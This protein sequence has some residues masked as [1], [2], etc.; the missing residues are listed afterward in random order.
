MTRDK[1]HRLTHRTWKSSTYIVHKGWLQASSNASEATSAVENHDF[2]R[3]ISIDPETSADRPF[4]PPLPPSEAASK[5]R[6]EDV[7]KMTP[8]E[9]VFMRSL[10]WEENGDDVGGTL[11]TDTMLS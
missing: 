1:A 4:D 6:C 9:L 2:K 5:G 8:E 3:D 7:F 10:G 11:F